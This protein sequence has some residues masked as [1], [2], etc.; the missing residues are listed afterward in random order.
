[1]IAPSLQLS[2]SALKV[3][4]YR[5]LRLAGVAIVQW[6]G[7]YDSLIDSAQGHFLL[8]GNNERV[9]KRHKPG[10]ALSLHLGT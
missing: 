3:A 2:T 6:K 8:A 1:M 4:H 7:A 5:L 9:A 10:A